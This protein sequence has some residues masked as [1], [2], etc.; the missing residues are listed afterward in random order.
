MAFKISADDFD[1]I[2]QD[3]ISEVLSFSL[4]HHEISDFRT[5]GK[6]KVFPNH[7]VLMHHNCLDDEAI[8]NETQSAT[9]TTP[10]KSMVSIPFCGTHL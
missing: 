9:K 5:N 8:N 3:F 6:G 4:E 1:I 2:D 7:I 10:L